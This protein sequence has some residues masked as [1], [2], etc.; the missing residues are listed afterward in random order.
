MN[1]LYDQIV[2]HP[3]ITTELDPYDVLWVVC[4]VL[5]DMEEVIMLFVILC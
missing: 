4:V 3:Y 1:P 5:E 2:I